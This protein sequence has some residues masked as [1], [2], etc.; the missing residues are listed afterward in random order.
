M[1]KEI[2]REFAASVIV[3]AIYTS[4]EH[5]AKKHG[6]TVRSL[7]RYR[8]AMANDAVLSQFVAT[9]KKAFEDRWADELMATVR[10]G[11]KF[12]TAAAIEAESLQKKNPEMI[13]AVAGAIKICGEVLIAKRMIDARLVDPNRAPG[14]LPRPDAAE[15]GPASGLV[16]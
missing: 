6:V 4:D 9:K 5:A 7:Q 10:A 12:L 14:E 15:A 2:D 1:G 3:E 16:H 13:R 8:K 11:G